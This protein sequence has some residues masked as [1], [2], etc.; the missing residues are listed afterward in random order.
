M[1]EAKPNMKDV[2]KLANVSIGTV[3]KYINGNSSIT[4]TNRA[5]IQQAIEKLKYT[6]N[7]AA[8]KLAS[9]QANSILLYIVHEDPV[10]TASWLYDLPIIQGISEFFSN[11]KYSLQLAMNPVHASDSIYN[12]IVTRYQQ[13]SISGVIVISPWPLDSRT[14]ISLIDMGVPYV[15]AGAENQVLHNFHVLMDNYQAV[16]QLMDHLA[17]MGHR[18]AAMING[19][20]AQ[21]DMLDRLRGFNDGLLRNQMVTAS[22]WNTFGEQT[23][24]G[25]YERMKKLLETTK[26]EERP[27]A[28]VCGNDYIAAGVIQAIR[29]SGLRVPEDISVTGYDDITLTSILEPAL[30]T[31]ALPTFN[32][33]MKS[34]EM[35]QRRL[36]QKSFENE[37]V[38]LPCSMVLRGSTGPAANG[39]D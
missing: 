22:Q 17:S 8:Q 15:L 30:T 6:P 20:N 12:N 36:D 28:V 32:L 33:G 7:V 10:S 13:K 35:M 5:R 37:A 18:R 39:T 3:S 14:L 11:S 16:G 25:G 29:E 23:V 31:V 4:P 24:T 34:A 26:P 38:V 21:H 1:S 27:T 9:G 2:A 19:L